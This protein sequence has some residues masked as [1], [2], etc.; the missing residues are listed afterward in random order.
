MD[1]GERAARRKRAAEYQE[2]RERRY[3]HEFA[4][5]VRERY[6]GC[7]SDIA[8]EVAEH[9]CRRHSGRIGRTAAAKALSDEAVDLAVQAHVR[10]QHTSYDDYLILMTGC[11][12]DV[13]REAVRED[14]ERVS[15]SWRTEDRR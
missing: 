12:R 9:A 13:A 3:V 11:D 14:V 5:A 1:A 2:R 6:P 7:P 15:A 4:R 10:H 8:M